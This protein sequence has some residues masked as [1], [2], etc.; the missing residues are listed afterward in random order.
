MKIKAIRTVVPREAGTYSAFPTAVVYKGNI[1]LY[2]RRGRTSSA[3]VHGLNGIVKRIKIATKEYLKAHLEPCEEPLVR[4]GDEKTVFAAGNELDAIV[5]KLEENLF[6]LCTR[7][8]VVGSHNTCFV[9]FSEEP[10]FCERQAVKIP[11]V[12]LHA[13]YGKP[14]KTPHGYVFTAYGAME[15]DGEQRPLLLVTDTKHWEWLSHLPSR[16]GGKRLN[17]CSLARHDGKWIL[18]IREDEP[19]FGIWYSES[20]DLQR[21]SPPRKV[22]NSAHAPMALTV[23]NTLHL[24]YR[25]LI[26]ENLSAV[27]LRSPW[28]GDTPLALERYQGSPYDG[29]YTDLFRAEGWLVVIYYLG[30]PQAEPLIRSSL[31]ET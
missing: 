9:S 3:Q 5:G 18:F 2:Y 17:E 20:S 8:C 4:L 6:S 11:G 23:E 1:Y 7:D 30:N 21:W 25:W 28:N 31:I 24:A 26:K 29:G 10:E 27:T 12:E 16:G 15:R 19:P 13:F 22:I 14:I